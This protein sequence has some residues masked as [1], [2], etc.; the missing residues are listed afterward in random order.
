MIMSVRPLFTLAFLFLASCGEDVLGPLNNTVHVL[1]TVDGESLPATVVDD[2][3]G[4]AW[5]VSADTIWLESGSKWRRHSAQHREP[6]VGGEPLDLETSGTVVRE[7]DGSLILA[8]ECEDADC[9]APDGLVQTETGLE[10]GGTYL[11]A[12]T[13]LVFRPI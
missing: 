4:L 2:L 13:N 9:L 1:H 10:I 6:G 3:G 8:F 11:H 7:E 5:V 12:G